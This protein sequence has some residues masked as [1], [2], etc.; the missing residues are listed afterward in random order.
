MLTLCQSTNHH[1][2]RKMRVYITSDVA[3]FEIICH[4]RVNVSVAIYLSIFTD[5][6]KLSSFI[7]VCVSVE[8]CY[9]TILIYPKIFVLVKWYCT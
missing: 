7:F 5:K 6:R 4:L 1:E 8:A 3:E 9:A 2:A